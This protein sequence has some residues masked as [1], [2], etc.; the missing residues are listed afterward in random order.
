MDESPRWLFS[1][2]RYKEAEAI[3]RKS[4]ARNNK[5]H[6]IPAEGLTEDHL[7]A[8]LPMRPVQNSEIAKSD[9]QHQPQL[10][11]PGLSMETGRSAPQFI[12]PQ[13]FQRE[14]DRQVTE[15]TQMTQT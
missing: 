2:G 15:A 7:R 10:V 13:K 12:W 11:K 14:V 9:A 8:A 5:L 6:L 4:L 3:V 1:Q